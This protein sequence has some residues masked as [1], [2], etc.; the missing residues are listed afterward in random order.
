[1]SKR[2]ITVGVTGLNNIDS[3]G[4]GIPVI[5][6]LKESTEF[7]V[8]IIGFSYETL[9]PGIYMH[10]L[11][12]KVYQLPLP[13]AGSAMLKERLQYITSIEKIDV[14]I[15][16]FDAELHSFI[17]LQHQL[18]SELGIAT[19]LPSHESFEERQKSELNKFGDKY[20]VKVPQSH[21]INQLIE[22]KKLEEEL[23]YPMVI[24]GR[25]YDAYIAS[26]YEQA[27]SYFY[28]IVA[29]WGYPVIVQE[30]V[31]GTEVNVTA[32]GDGKGKC[33]GAVP[34]RKLYITDKGKAWSG[35][36]LEDD[37]LLEI[38]R[39]VIE[40]S[41]WR[42]GCE[43]EFIKTKNDEY[44]LLEMNPRF[45]AWV[46]LANGCGQNHPEALVKMALGEDVQPLTEYESGKMFIRYS[47]DLIV[48]ISEFEKISTTGEI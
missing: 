39:H 16:N 25:Y 48:D 18:K 32:I 40:N 2:K 27:S 46:Y 33:I 45:P 38:S 42:G 14:I 23:D 47:Y 29:K 9:E 8:R 13:T 24:K 3:P 10:E 4:P 6:A 15:P 17:K 1:M 36:S 22:L 34:M 31:T 20:D 21:M 12:D 30:F 11:V 28:K 43:L 41:K 37:K 19:F 26:T 35:I 7:D 5:R 44:Y